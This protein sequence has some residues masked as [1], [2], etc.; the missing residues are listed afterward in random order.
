MKNYLGANQTDLKSS[1]FHFI[2]SPGKL[3]VDFVGQRDIG[4]FKSG[5]NMNQN[6]HTHIRMMY[7]KHSYSYHPETSRFGKMD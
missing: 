7:V 4:I 5:I 2:I 1:L 3:K 6:N